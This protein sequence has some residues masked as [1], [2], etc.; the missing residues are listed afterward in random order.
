MHLKGHTWQFRYVVRNT[1]TVPIA[2]F[3]LTSPRANLFH[4]SGQSNWSY[5]GSGVCGQK[6]ADILIYWSTATRSTRVIRPKHTAQFAFRVN[7][8]G[9]RKMLYSLSW[10]AAAPQFGSIAG[11]AASSL[12][13]S[14]P[15]GR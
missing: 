14:G 12:Q 7:T 4:I 15:C 3:Q 6:H 13:T 1:G 9:I 2:G 8:T 11:P 5:Y 10:D